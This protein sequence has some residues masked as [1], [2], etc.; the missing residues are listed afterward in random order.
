MT[1][2]DALLSRHRLEIDGTGEVITI[3]CRA[4]G[5]SANILP[6]IEWAGLLETVKTIHSWP[7]HHEKEKHE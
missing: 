3:F 1:A 4:C 7:H 6:D 5:R 2:I